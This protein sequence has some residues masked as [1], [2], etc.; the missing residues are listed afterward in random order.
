MSSVRVKQPDSH[1]QQGSVVLSEGNDFAPPMPEGKPL[2]RRTATLSR[3][4]RDAEHSDSSATEPSSRAAT[5]RRKRFP[6]RLQSLRNSRHSTEPMPPLPTLDVPEEH[7]YEGAT[8]PRAGSFD[9]QMAM[10]SSPRRRTRKIS[11]EGE[12]TPGR[13]RKIST[14]GRTRKISSEGRR[15]VSAERDTKHK[16]ESAAVEGDDEGY[17]ELLS[18]YESEDQ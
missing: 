9:E 10:P 2:S 7:D 14:E 15:K 4:H 18:A 6:P 5:L 11:G 16:R 12:S 17:N 8:T 13:T 1:R 3:A